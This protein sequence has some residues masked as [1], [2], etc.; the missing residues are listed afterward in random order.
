[1]ANE[2]ET[3]GTE[4]VVQKG[5]QLALLVELENL[6]VGGRGIVFD[7]LRTVLA[8]KGIT[9]R[10]S[11]F[12]RYCIHR[13]PAQYLPAILKL[14]DKTRLSDE[15]LAGEI[16]E[17]VSLS[18]ADGGN[19]LNA[20]FT[21]LLDAAEKAGMM[22]GFL[23][24]CSEETSSALLGRLGVDQETATVLTCCGDT[25]HD[26]TPDAWLKLAKQLGVPPRQSIAVTTSSLSCKAALSAAMRCVAVPDDYTEFQDFGGADMVLDELT[27]E[28]AT[29]ILA[30]LEE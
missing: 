2:S 30:L 23:S 3:P 28:V 8:D 29:P 12:S 26:P 24:C 14:A 25:K 4:T 10:P 6:A 15:K 21:A 13:S 20:G 5:P 18:M 22:I 17:G 19:K 16:L 11:M 27:S 9:L 1:M 7:V